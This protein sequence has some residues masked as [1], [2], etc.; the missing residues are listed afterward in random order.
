MKGKNIIKFIIKI[1][2]IVF[3]FSYTI[4]K[5]GYYEYNLQSRKN[6]TEKEI[7]KF[8]NDIKSGKNIDIKDYL[9]ETTTDYS[10]DLTRATSSFSLNLN[11]YLI[12]TINHAINIFS[13]LVK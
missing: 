8:E 10:N 1:I 3:I 6:M 13:K 12:Q 4:Q 5:N 2:L 11:R 7:K 9:N